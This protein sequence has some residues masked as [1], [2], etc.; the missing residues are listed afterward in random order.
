MEMIDDFI[1]VFLNEL[2]N[3][4]PM[5]YMSSQCLRK[6][7]YK[8]FLSKPSGLDHNIEDQ[9]W[10]LFV[11]K[12][13]CQGINAV[14]E[15]Y[16]D[17]VDHEDPGKPFHPVHPVNHWPLFKMVINE[18]KVLQVDQWNISEGA[19]GDITFWCAFRDNAGN[20]RDMKDKNLMT[21]IQKNA[22]NLAK[23]SAFSDIADILTMVSTANFLTPGLKNRLAVANTQVNPPRPG[24]NEN[25]WELR[26]YNKEVMLSCVRDHSMNLSLLYESDDDYVDPENILA[27]PPP[28][29]EDLDVDVEAVEMQPQPGPSGLGAAG[30]ST[31]G[32]TPMGPGGD[33]ITD[34]MLL[35][36]NR[37]RFDPLT[38]LVV[39]QY[40]SSIPEPNLQQRG[41][42]TP[43]RTP[44]TRVQHRAAAAYFATQQAITASPFAVQT[45]QLVCRTLYTQGI[46][47]VTQTTTPSTGQALTTTEMA[48]TSPG[49]ITT[50]VESLTITGEPPVPGTSTGGAQGA[51]G[52]AQGAV[53]GST[54]VTPTISPT[55]GKLGSAFDK[56]KQKISKKR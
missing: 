38:D 5:T 11:P 13:N 37:V 35:R 3:L 34:E 54:A 53:G 44:R 16:I 43:T 21:E 40:I 8:D 42:W 18:N 23:Q 9:C 46:S 1:D 26:Y 51:V 4:P 17:A 47:K 29:M 25:D 32:P 33:V 31:A 2:I 6:K 48:P 15:K 27:E 55:K 41:I 22:K 30:L 19:F 50:A 45:Q 36:T 24:P 28:E 49:G 52:G 10:H 12:Y 39:R 7:H 14:P 20:A 56:L